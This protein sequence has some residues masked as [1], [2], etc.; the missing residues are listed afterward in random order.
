MVRY[1]L[2]AHRCSLIASTQLQRRSATSEQQPAV[3]LGGSI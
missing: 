1:Q 3:S 2:I